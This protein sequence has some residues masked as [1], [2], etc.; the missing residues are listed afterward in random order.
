MHTSPIKEIGEYKRE[1][2]MMRYSAT[3]VVNKFKSRCCMFN[4]TYV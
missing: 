3:N 4:D 1:G 2:H